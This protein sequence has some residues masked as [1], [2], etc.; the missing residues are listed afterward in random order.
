MKQA[1][2]LLAMLL[3]AT[4]SAESI[5][6]NGYDV[7]FNI[8]GPYKIEN[9]SNS[10]TTIINTLNGLVSIGVFHYDIPVKQSA[11]E[12]LRELYPDANIHSI[13]IDGAEGVYTI[14]AGSFSDTFTAMYFGYN[15]TLGVSIVSSLPFYD[16]ADFLRSLHIKPLQEE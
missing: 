8:T 12:S 15:Q 3:M 5:A 14:F 11:L 7:N 16:N 10:Q 6:I 9:D 4:A 13:I 1:I 2:I